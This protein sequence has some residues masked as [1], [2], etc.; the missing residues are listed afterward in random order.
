ML[1]RH[2]ICESLVDIQYFRLDN[3]VFH[4]LN[5]RFKKRLFGKSLFSGVLVISIICENTQKTQENQEAV[6]SVQMEL[7][8]GLTPKRITGEMIILSLYVYRHFFN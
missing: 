3:N 8:I 4:S 1:I 7:H 6:H 2:T 5:I